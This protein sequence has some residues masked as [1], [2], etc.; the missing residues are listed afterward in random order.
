MTCDF[1]RARL[2][3][4]DEYYYFFRSWPPLLLCSTLSRVRTSAPRPRERPVCHHLLLQVLQVLQVL[5]HGPRTHRLAR[6]G[7]AT[8]ELRARSHQKRA[9]GAPLT[10]AE[11]S[12]GALSPLAAARRQSRADPRLGPASS[13]ACALRAPPPPPLSPP[14]T[15]PPSCK[16]RSG[17]GRSGQ[18]RA[19]YS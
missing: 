8:P 16:V 4:S 5:P 6:A 14:P 19:V 1:A 9:R 7:T 15:P 12:P 18:V 2:A 13:P 11:A 3:K 10:H 17:Q